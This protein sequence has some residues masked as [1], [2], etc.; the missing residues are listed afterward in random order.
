M[1]V[2]FT[3][4]PN[5]QESFDPGRDFIFLPYFVSLKNLSDENS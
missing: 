2:L 1:K 3:F 5:R 4:G